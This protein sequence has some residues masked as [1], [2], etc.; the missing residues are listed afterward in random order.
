M[1][2][3]EQRHIVVTKNVVKSGIGFGACL[4]MIISWSR[5]QSVLW[6]IIHGILGWFYVIWYVLFLRH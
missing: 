5:N 4:A 1:R 3:E 2:N 6:A